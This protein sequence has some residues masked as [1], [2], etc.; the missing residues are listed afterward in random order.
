MLARAMLHLFQWV[1]AQEGSDERPEPVH[2]PAGRSRHNEPAAAAGDTR[3]AGRDGPAVAV[4]GMPLAQRVGAAREDLLP[5]CR[6]AT[7]ALARLLPA[8]RSS[9]AAAPPRAPCSRFNAAN[10]SNRVTALGRGSDGDGG[11]VWQPGS[12]R[13]RDASPVGDARTGDGGG[14]APGGWRVGPAV[15]DSLSLWDA[16][17]L[18]RQQASDGARPPETEASRRG[19][20]Q[21]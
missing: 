7:V 20:Y 1:L 5:G 13:A 9:L 16:V 14:R 17:Q 4:R 3:A 18:L 2:L 19:G 10:G 21:S 8:A 6:P 15:G 11:D 12:V